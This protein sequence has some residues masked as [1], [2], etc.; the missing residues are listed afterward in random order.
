M[1]PTKMRSHTRLA[2]AKWSLGEPRTPVGSQALGAASRHLR[3]A[4]GITSRLALR[5]RWPGLH[6]EAMTVTHPFRAL[7]LRLQT[8][9]RHTHSQT[10]MYSP[11]PH[12]TATASPRPN[13]QTEANRQLMVPHQTIVERNH[14]STSFVREIV[15]NTALAQPV[16]AI[17]RNRTV[18]FVDKIS[19]PLISRSVPGNIGPAASLAIPRPRHAIAQSGNEQ[20][21]PESVSESLPE[22]MVRKHRRIEARAFLQPRGLA[23]QIVAAPTLQEPAV[24]HATLARQRTQQRFAEPVESPTRPHSARQASNINVAQ[25]TDAVLQQL[26]RRLIGARERMGRI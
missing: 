25:I 14:S 16:G 11:A 4:S 26:D 18:E 19:L 13:S 7:I 22:R 5:S 3:W 17:Q 2:L 20:D 12:P 6:P 10:L 9:L 24:S 8:L 21:N 1:Y 23:P 15:G